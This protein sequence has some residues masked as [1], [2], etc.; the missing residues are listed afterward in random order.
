V[1]YR[2]NNRS[3]VWVTVLLLAITQASTAGVR[4]QV[5]AT[6]DSSK[7]EATAAQLNRLGNGPALVRE[8]SGL[9]KVFTREYDSTAEANFARPALKGAGYL[10][11]FAVAEGEANTSNS[12]TGFGGSVPSIVMNATFDQLTN[13]FV[14]AKP[15]RTEPR[16]TSA[17]EGLNDEAISESLLFKKCMAY[18]KKSH[19][20]SAINSIQV[21]VRRFPTSPNVAKAKVM[22]AYW[23][24]EMPNV[25]GALEQFTSVSLEHPFAQEA[26]EANL[27]VGYVQLKSQEYAKALRTFHSVASTTAPCSAEVRG[28]AILRTAALFHRG[29]DHDW[30]DQCY[31]LAEQAISAPEAK[32]FAAMQRTAIALE[33]AWNGK[34]TF[35]QARSKGE[36]MLSTYASAPKS[37]RS[38]T[39]LMVV[40]T[41][42]YE[43]NFVGAVNKEASI[44]TEVSGTREAPLAYYWLA[45]ARFET[46][47]TTG[48]LAILNP[49]IDANLPSEDRFQLVRIT[50]QA[51]KL[52]AKAYARL[53]DGDRAAE[54]DGELSNP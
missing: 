41:F 33:K 23:L 21:Y 53:G 2:R 7:A 24:L 25:K 48:A 16:I 19:A 49:L 3:I 31:E 50:P 37:I 1:N 18:W 40:E 45:K 8:A 15:L 38:T 5:L 13:D 27:R 43:K 14:I 12:T 39:A 42:C 6:G 20:D 47:D 30:A 34:G 9:F 46:G 28:E 26:S 4:L 52:A 54:L 10:D 36:A 51:R 35:T 11:L 32:A 44:L 22:R 17:Q 29:K